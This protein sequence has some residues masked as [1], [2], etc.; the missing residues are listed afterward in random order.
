MYE[1]V[2]HKLKEAGEVMVWMDSGVEH[3]LHLHNVSFHDD[4][5]VFK[6]DAADEIHWINGDKIER[7]WVHKDF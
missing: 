2:K 4:N 3:E 7:Y 1:Q 6:V 5:N